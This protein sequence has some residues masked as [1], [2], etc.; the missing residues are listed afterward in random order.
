MTSQRKSTWELCPASWSL[1]RSEI[2]SALQCSERC[3]LFM[4]NLLS[5]QVS[6]KAFAVFASTWSFKGE[7]S[8]QPAFNT[9]RYRICRKL[10]LSFILR[11][12]VSHDFAMMEK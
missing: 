2:L 4:V 5:I 1:H 9:D 3:E 7:R 11:S 10:N 6:W 8:P 12:H